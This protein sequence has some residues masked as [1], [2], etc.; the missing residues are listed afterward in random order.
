MGR[1]CF[2]RRDRLRHSGARRNRRHLHRNCRR[3]HHCRH[4]AALRARPHSARRTHRHL[5][6]RQWLKTTDSCSGAYETNKAIR[7]RLTDFE[8]FVEER[9]AM[10]EALR[11]GGRRA[12][13]VRVLLPN[14]FQKHTNNVREIS[15]TAANLPELVTEIEGKLSGVAAAPARRGRT[16]SPLHQLLCQRRRYPLPRQRE[17]SAFRKAMR[18]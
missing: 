14:A 13:S 17:I 10:N 18:S 7:P 16:D 8:N 3:R 12:M 9:N 6:H 11:A 5:H 2:G 4:S 15:T 1:R